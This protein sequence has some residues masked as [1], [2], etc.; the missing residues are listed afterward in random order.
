M[1]LVLNTCKDEISL[2]KTVEQKQQAKKRNHGI[3]TWEIC[4]SQVWKL[5]HISQ[6]QI[7]V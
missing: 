5:A 7:K 2:F 3:Q 6:F 4:I 1:Q